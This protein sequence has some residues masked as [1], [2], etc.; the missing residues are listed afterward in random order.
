MAAG[1]KDAT[2]QQRWRNAMVLT[3]EEISMVAASLYNM[4]DWHAMLGRK[5]EH[6]VQ[7]T[8][9]SHVGCTFGRIPIVTHLGDFLQLKPTGQMSLVDDMEARH[10]DGSWKY[11][12]VSSEIQRAQKLF[13]SVPDVFELRGTMRFV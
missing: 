11:S 10:P 6:D 4:L 8:S 9:Y 2:L 13:C 5:L 7:E 3:T 1:N 12:D